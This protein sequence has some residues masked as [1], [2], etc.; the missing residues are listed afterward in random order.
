MEYQVIEAKG[1]AYKLAKAVNE[2]IQEGWVPLG[3]AAVGFSD[4]SG[5]WWFYQAMTRSRTPP[6]DK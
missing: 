1:E 6:S 3:G 4:Q 5:N 2:K